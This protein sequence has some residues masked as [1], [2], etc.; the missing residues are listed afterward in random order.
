MKIRSL[1]RGRTFTAALL[2]ILVMSRVHAQQ[3]G[4]AKVVKAIQADAAGGLYVGNR[5]PLVP[6]PLVKLPPGSITP[7]GWLRGQLEA[8]AKGMTGHLQEISKWCKFDGN[9][10]ADPQGQGH[11]GWEELPYWL[12]GYGDLGYVLKDQR[13]IQDA[14]KWIDAMLASQ[15]ADGWF[16]P[17]AL[18]TGVNGKPNV[19]PHMVMLNVL[20]SYYERGKDPRV[21]PFMMRYFRWQNRVPEGDLIGGWAKPRRGD[22]L[23]S[24]YWLYNRTGEKWLLDLAARIHR[25]GTP[26]ALGQIDLHGV[27][28]T[29]GF[30]EPAVYFLQ[31]R[32]KKYLE[33]AEHNYEKVM[34]TY[35]QF[36]GGG[37]ASDEVCRKGYI[38][39]H[40]GFETCSMVEYMHSFQML[41]KISGDPLWADRCEEVA[42]N[43]LPAALTADQ[44][45]LHYLTGANMVKLDKQ[46]HAPGIMNRGT[47]LSYSPYAIYRCCQHNV[48]HGWPYYAEEL[49]LATHDNG[50]CAS[51]YAASEVEAKIGDGTVVK[52]A[53][54]TAYP[55]AETIQFK[56]SLPRAARFPLYLRV[57]RWCGQPTVRLNNTAMAVA[58]GPLSYIVLEREWHDGD[59]VELRLPMRRSVRTWAKNQNAVSVDY[60]PLT[61]SLM[62][63]EDYRRYGGTPA[64]PELEVYPTTPWNYGLVL[65]PKTPAASLELV[66]TES[67]GVAQPF[68]PENAPIRIRAQAKKIRAW[69]LDRTGLA[70][71]L[72]PSPVR[73][74]EPLETVTLIPMGAARLR[75]TAFP[76]IGSGADAHEWQEIR[77]PAGVSASA[78]HVGKRD[79]LD[80]LN[81]GELP[82]SSDD[83]SMPRFTWWDHKG[84]AES[85]PK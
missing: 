35:G 49:W 27:N 23:E 4:D 75:I 67:P 83:E 77:K 82:S 79:T 55:F 65:D 46:N 54:D 47:M 22:N 20:Q 40:Q 13:I 71:K 28:F 25:L 53:E 59:T 37:F 60:G 45:A 57:P 64:W 74:D 7:K 31:A 41:T 66:R 9:A 52:I 6:S 61:F 29:Q 26:W 3:L 2:C 51:L 30:R 63:G 18:R 17:R 72:Q 8:Q 38:D 11:S 85:S 50:L 14:R 12:K 80:A 68:T 43:S 16:G 56:L 70:G 73:S 42:F 21:L 24:I 5:E 1:T 34:G 48:S 32:E 10:W 33:A 19:W 62:I 84:T 58:A 78:S 76:T 15:E 44:K 36:P 81:D 69:T 39:P